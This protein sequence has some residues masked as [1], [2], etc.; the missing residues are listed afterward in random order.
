MGL[1]CR[2]RSDSGRQ[3]DTGGAPPS[4]EFAH[5]EGTNSGTYF[6]RLSSQNLG[7]D[8]RGWRCHSSEP[9]L[10]DNLNGRIDDRCTEEAA[11]QE[12]SRSAAALLDKETPACFKGDG[13]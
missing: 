8:D 11:S 10:G 13:R 1:V 3:R 6:K 7:K 5:L 9:F 4:D 12:K 2:P